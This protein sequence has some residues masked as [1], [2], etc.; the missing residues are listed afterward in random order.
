MKSQIEN[1]L[2][3]IVVLTTKRTLSRIDLGLTSIDDYYIFA[4]MLILKIRSN[5]Y[6]IQRTDYEIKKKMIIQKYFLKSTSQ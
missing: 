4:I 3:K 1:N 2:K 5:L 6:L